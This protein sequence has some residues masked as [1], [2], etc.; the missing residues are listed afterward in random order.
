MTRLSKM[1]PAAD[2]LRSEDRLADYARSSVSG[3]GHIS[4]TCRMGAAR[5]PFAVVDSH[6]QLHGMHGLYVADA[7]IMPSVPSANT[8][9]PTIMVAEKIAHHL[10]A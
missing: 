2:M 6:G 1:T 4:G 5:D 8:H 3:T 9:L 7:S 10:L